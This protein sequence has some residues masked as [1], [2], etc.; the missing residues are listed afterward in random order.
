MT[1][2]VNKGSKFE[3]KVA[4]ILRKI[5][6]E[7]K[8]RPRSGANKMIAGYGDIYTKLPYAIECKNHAKLSFWKWWEQAQSQSSMARPPVLIFTSNYRPTMLA[9][10]LDDWIN[11]YQE[12][13]DWKKEAQDLLN[14]KYKR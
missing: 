10:K 11:L 9:M 13:L 14:G 8:R 12:M 6:P 5:A 4:G 2:T 7:T 1:K 3:Y